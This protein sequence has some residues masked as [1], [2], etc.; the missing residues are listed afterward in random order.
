VRKPD[1][2]LAPGATIGILGAGQLGRMLALAGARLGLKSHIYAPDA[3]EPAFD[4]AAAGTVAPYEDPAA[5]AR[6]ADAVDVITY[7]FENIPAAT[8]AFLAGRRP[9][10]PGPLALA[11]T[12]DRLIEKRFLND[13]GVATAGFAQIDSADAIA[14]AL[15]KFA[16][17]GILKTRRFGYDGKGQAMLRDA[18]G[19]ALMFASFGG[20]PA[21]LESVV[22]FTREISAV[23]ARGRDGS[24]RAYD[25]CE[26]SHA[27]HI[28]SRTEAPAAIKPST[29]Q[30]AKE[31]AKCIADA[32]DYVGVIAVE[33]FV[34]D[35]ASGQELIVNE[36]APR[37][38][39][40]GH[41]TI[42]GAVTSQFEQHIRAI[43][44]WPLGSTGRRGRIVMDNLIGDEARGWREILE[45]DGACLHL[46]GKSEIRD[47][48]KMGHVT[49]VYPE[50]PDQRG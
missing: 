24:F 39:N 10:H 36:I 7:E 44:G 20:V 27:N 21:I 15:E 50:E 1:R 13:L 31:I 40:S 28:L 38:H 37:V 41:W 29:E 46:Y 19:G 8:A 30:R 17:V 26:N 49:R 2:D 3:G 11:K 47:G 45:E 35:G 18:S 9:V 34:L 23:G 48:R 5:L 16:G 25:I 6:F 22:S 12:Q 42:D 4:V 32:L 33:M 14:P 43:S